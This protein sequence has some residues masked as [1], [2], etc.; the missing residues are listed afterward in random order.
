M[1]GQKSFAK[2]VGGPSEGAGA[3]G[4]VG[5]RAGQARPPLCTPFPAGRACI[6]REGGS[7]WPPVP[8]GLQSYLAQVGKAREAPSASRSGLHGVAALWPPV[9][10]PQGP[11]VCSGPRLCGVRS[12]CQRCFPTWNRR[13]LSVADSTKPPGET[14]RC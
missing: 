3:L 10:C 2:E 5:R 6:N 7:L 11:P 13:F 14:L 8:P 12:G 4:C 9:P 1:I